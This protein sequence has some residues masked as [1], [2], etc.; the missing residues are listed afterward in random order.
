MVLEA[1]IDDITPRTTGSLL[2]RA[3]AEGALEIFFTPIHDE[4]GRP[5]TQVTVW[6]SP[7]VSTISP[8]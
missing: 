1:T 2:E 6:R 3:L 4:E 8:V 7:T 5:E